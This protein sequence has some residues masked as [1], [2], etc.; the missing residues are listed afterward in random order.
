MVRSGKV[1]VY[2]GVS[3]PGVPEIVKML[4]ILGVMVVVLV[5]NSWKV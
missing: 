4:L 5:A 1:K 3:K 2:N